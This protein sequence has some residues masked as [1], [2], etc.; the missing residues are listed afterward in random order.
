MV[1]LFS[2]HLSVTIASRPTSYGGREDMPGGSRISPALR[3]R[4]QDTG[5]TLRATL[6]G[7]GVRIFYRSRFPNSPCHLPLLRAQPHTAAM[8]IFRQ[9]R[10]LA[11]LYIG[12]F[13]I[14]DAH[15]AR[16]SGELENVILMCV[17]SSISTAVYRC[18]VRNHIQ[19]PGEPPRGR[20]GSSL[21][22][23]WGC[24]NRCEVREG[25]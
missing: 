13:K 15:C 16:R 21:S 7:N 8:G 2:L 5:R 1:A 25:I 9:I 24:Q 23:R 22:D 20:F 6:R 18:A 3:R 19:R 14:L 12:R 11:M 10:R 4:I 17:V